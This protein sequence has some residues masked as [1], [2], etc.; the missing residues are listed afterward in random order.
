M[1][2]LTLKGN[3]WDKYHL[4]VGV[5]ILQPGTMNGKNY[6]IHR[7]QR[8][9]IWWDPYSEW[10]IGTKDRLGYNHGS[11]SGPSGNS[12]WPIF[13]KEGWKYYIKKNDAFYSAPT[14]E[15]QFTYYPKES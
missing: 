9:G 12:N 11:I 2:K 14:G 3:V 10:M 6:W 7:S 8:F 1:M 4:Y 13:V 5:Y 15:V